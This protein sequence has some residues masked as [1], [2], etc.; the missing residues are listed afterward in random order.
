M[1][2]YSDRPFPSN[3]SQMD[4]VICIDQDH[5]RTLGVS[6]GQSKK[7]LVEIIYKDLGKAEGNHKKFVALPSS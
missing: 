3:L 7:G 2:E 1:V 6:I 5:G 4:S